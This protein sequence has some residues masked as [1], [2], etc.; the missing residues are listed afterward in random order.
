MA[1]VN[2]DYTGFFVTDDKSGNSVRVE[3]R[4]ED[5]VAPLSFGC[6][7]RVPKFCDHIEKGIR[8]SLDAKP[9]QYLLESDPIKVMVPIFPRLDL[10]RLVK[11][12]RS[13]VNP[14]AV[15]VSCKQAFLGVLADGEG[16]QA[17]R[18]MIL[19][20]VEAEK[21]LECKS[22]GH[23][24]SSQR[25]IERKTQEGDKLWLLQN[26]YSIWSTDHCLGC[27]RG[28]E[29]ENIFEEFIPDL[30][31]LGISPRSWSLFEEMY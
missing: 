13:T 7:C 5:G 8:N 20:A 18:G 26:R 23:R 4:S 27:R 1:A 19:S 14:A 17:I 2:A 3:L 12:E 15:K 10:Y 9:L 31:E 25:M 28:I 30:K 21:D 11:L 6:Q 29:T 16:M 24:Y 22:T